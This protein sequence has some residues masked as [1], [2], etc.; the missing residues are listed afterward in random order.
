MDADKKV[1]ITATS[2]SCCGGDSEGELFSN[3]LNKNS[4]IEVVENYFLDYS[5]AIGRLESKLTF[6]ECLE[7]KAQEL[8]DKS[9]IKNFESTLLLVG[10]SVGGMNT[11]ESIY[12]KDGDY[13]NINPNLHN[14]N[15]IDFL[16]QKKFKF[17]DS[18][19]FSTACTSSANAIGFAYEVVKKGLYENVV[20]LGAD[21]LSKT[22][23]GGFL[24]LGV[25]SSMP[26]NPFDKNRDGMN[27]SEAI[28][29]LLIQSEPTKN[30]VEICGV[31]YS[32]DAYHI[33]HPH[34]QGLGA[35]KAIKNAL[36][37][38]NI[39]SEQ[40][41]YINAHGTGTK[42]NDNIEAMALESIFRHNPDI[43]STK[44]ITGHSLGAA[45]SLEAIISKLVLENQILPPN[46]FLENPENRNINLLTKS[47]KQEVNYV[48]SNSFAF[49][50]NNCSLVFKRVQ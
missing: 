33:T 17:K 20:V 31:G 48:L 2:L 38:A 16:L 30:S 37:S 23:M 49:G 26:C 36:D 29:Y 5:I 8:L 47:K 41:E 25:L 12:I 50:G 6:Y 14:I 19:S 42:A 32:S 40:V 45:G 1:F 3:I 39:Q 24:S 28:A 46:T 4:G 35:K 18:F 15:T 9:N 22:T 13:T 7:S 43:S 11:T 10:S 27:V 44:S 21:A 34:P